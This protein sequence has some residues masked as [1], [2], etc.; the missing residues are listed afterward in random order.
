M[1]SMQKVHT[2]KAPLAVGPYSQAV[3][4]NGFIFLSGAIAIDPSNNSM[5]TDWNVEKQTELAFKNIAEVLKAAGS[6]MD[7]ICKIN[8]YILTMDDFPVV[9]EVYSKFFNSNLPARACVAVSQ[10]PKNAK[11]EIEVIAVE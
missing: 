8:V 1:N 9:N 10:L 11:V 5:M 2:D 6:S 3:K 7:K 4:A